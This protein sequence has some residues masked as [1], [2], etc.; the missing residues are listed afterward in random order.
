M[1]TGAEICITKN[2]MIIMG[3]AIEH[4]LWSN[5]ELIAIYVISF[6]PNSH[7]PLWERYYHPQFPNEDTVIWRSSEWSS[8]SYDRKW[9]NL[10]PTQVCLDL[11]F[12]PCCLLRGQNGIDRMGEVAERDFSSDLGGG[13][14]RVKLF[15]TLTFC[16]VLKNKVECNVH[17]SKISYLC[18]GHF[19]GVSSLWRMT[20]VLE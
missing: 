19:Q 9:Q 8:R 15:A 5:T 6:N 1:N 7:F 3:Y 12:T 13:G 4:L 11:K 20:T 14:R 18:C 16:S 2:E 10:D 17:S